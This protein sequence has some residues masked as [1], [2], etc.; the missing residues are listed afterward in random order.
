M[1]SLTLPDNRL[2]NVRQSWTR[3][4]PG[5]PK[6]EACEMI[7]WATGAINAKDTVKTIAQGMQGDP[8]EPLVTAACLSAGGPWGDQISAFPAPLHLK[9]VTSDAK[10]GR[11]ASQQQAC[12]PR[13]VT[14]RL[15]FRRRPGQ[16]SSCGAQRRQQRAPIRDHRPGA[17]LCETPLPDEPHGEIPRFRSRICARLVQLSPP[18][19]ACPPPRLACPG[20]RARNGTA[21]V[22]ARHS[23][24]SH[25]AAS[26]HSVAR[27]SL[28]KNPK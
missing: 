27:C 8:A 1:P 16:A 14:S 21:N 23:R 19:L 11:A 26:R 28:R 7:S 3:A 22:A 15:T 17:S 6:R 13:T 12:L 5:G 20:R 25:A 4:L 9:R 24:S 2:A 18:R 10:L